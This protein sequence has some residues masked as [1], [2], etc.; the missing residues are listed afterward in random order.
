MAVTFYIANSIEETKNSHSWLQFEEEVHEF[1][2]QNKNLIGDAIEVLVDLDPY[3]DKVFSKEEMPLLVS[4]CDV[5]TNEFNTSAV[6]EF[7]KGLKEFC[8]KALTEGKT[9]VALGD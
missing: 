3:G 8:E 4:L 5:L 2:Y 7:S 1:L 6:I 9:I